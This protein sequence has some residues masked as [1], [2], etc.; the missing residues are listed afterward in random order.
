[1]TK[2][3]PS[4]EGGSF[5]PSAQPDWNGSVAIGVVMGTAEEPRV[6]PFASAVVADERLL[7]L[8][9]PVHPTEVF[10]FSA[11]CLQGGCQH[12]REHKCNLVTQIVQLLPVV[13]EAL[14]TC[15]I[16]P[17]CRWWQQEGR[18]ACM[19]CPQVVT[20]NYNPS[21]DM[22]TAAAPPAQQYQTL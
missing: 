20:D 5:C 7:S 2:N 22:R 17:S 16:R 15:V 13:L 6:S 9:G 14:P 3:F 21:A 12:F 8:S 1:M 4:N 11:P 18:A 10:R 19:R